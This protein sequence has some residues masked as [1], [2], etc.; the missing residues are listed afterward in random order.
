[1]KKQILLLVPFLLVTLSLIGQSIEPAQP[2]KA[3][4]YFTRTSALGFAINFSYFDSTKLIGVFNGPKYIRYECEPGTHLFWARSENRDF[5]EAEVEAGKIYFVEAVVK[6]GAIKAGVALEPVDPNDTKM[7]NKIFKLMN[8][9]PSESFS[10][11]ELQAETER[12]QDAII[13]GMEK[14]EQEKKKGKTNSQL[15][16]SMY[17]NQ[18]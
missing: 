6:M 8:K 13:R 14:Y 12:L 3:V 2:D 5:I 18:N 9:K 4:I 16:K 15:T 10:T 11:E 17:Y 7:M 1:M